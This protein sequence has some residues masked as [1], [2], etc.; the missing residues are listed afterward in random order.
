MKNKQE[1]ARHFVAT[2]IAKNLV[3]LPDLKG[4]LIR[5]EVEQLLWDF[6]QSMQNDPNYEF[7]H[8]RRES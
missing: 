1:I 5:E 6:E 3:P 2:L 8:P 7:G 4:N